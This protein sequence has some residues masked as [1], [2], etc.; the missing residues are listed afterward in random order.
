MLCNHVQIGR[1]SGASRGGGESEGGEVGSGASRCY[2]G[3][4]AAPSIT[5]GV[6]AVDNVQEVAQACGNA[7]VCKESF[8]FKPLEELCVK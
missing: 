4:G 3:Q 6:G 1:S 8:P 5:G 2:R 7:I